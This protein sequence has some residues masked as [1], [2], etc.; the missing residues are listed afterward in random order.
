MIGALDLLVD[1]AL[2]YANRL[3]RAAVP[4]ELHVYAGASHGIGLAPGRVAASL[5]QELKA[6]LTQAF[7]APLP[8]S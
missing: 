4:T 3:L 2:E 6:A 7:T 8:G 5:D 1:E